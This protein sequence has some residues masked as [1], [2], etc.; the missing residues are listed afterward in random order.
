MEDSILETSRLR[1]VDRI[2]DSTDIPA[3]RTRL[4]L[5]RFGG[6][7]GWL[8]PEIQWT[9]PE[10]MELLHE[11]L[12]QELG[13][14]YHLGGNR[15][16]S[17]QHTGILKMLA[18]K[19]EYEVS[20]ETAGSAVRVGT[21]V[22][23]TA[24]HVIR[25]SNASEVCFTDL[26]S[27]GNVFRFTSDDIVESDDYDVAAIVFPELPASLEVVP[28]APSELITEESV[29]RSIGFGLTEKALATQFEKNHLDG[30][31]VS[32]LACESDADV[33]RYKCVR[34]KELVAGATNGKAYRQDSGGALLVKR[35]FDDDTW[36]LAGIIRAN[37]TTSELFA[38]CYVR[39]DAFR[40]EL[41][42]KLEDAGH[43]TF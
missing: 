14:N 25:D 23:L 11:M 31:I 37:G 28:I 20:M 4:F 22:V 43:P 36:R 32:S 10:M 42:R 16:P 15:T 34:G 41:N 9:S 8:N 3:D 29:Y 30:I 39:V 13:R 1:A 24:K 7:N 21:R 5:E 2:F 27:A 26:T 18:D 12:L 33:S 35:T 40:D 6:K 19:G 38:A 17:G